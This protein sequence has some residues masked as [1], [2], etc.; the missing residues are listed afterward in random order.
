MDNLSLSFI[1]ADSHLTCVVGVFVEC[2]KRNG[3][4]GDLCKRTDSALECAPSD[5]SGQELV[6]GQQL[7]VAT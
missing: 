2:E 5:S 4:T 3:G 6:Q 7:L 1:V